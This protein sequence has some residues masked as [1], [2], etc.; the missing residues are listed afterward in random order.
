MAA[1]MVISIRQIKEGGGGYKRYHFHHQLPALWCSRN[2]ILHHFVPRF[3]MKVAPV[4]SLKG[5]MA[6]KPV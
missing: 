1:R 4:L 3:G 2:L 6:G 5:A